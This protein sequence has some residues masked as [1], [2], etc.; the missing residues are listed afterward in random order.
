MKFFEKM[1]ERDLKKSF[2]SFGNTTDLWCT[3]YMILKKVF[4]SHPLLTS[5][6]LNEY[7]K[8]NFPN[9]IY[10]KMISQFGK[11]SILVQSYCDLMNEN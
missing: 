9:S 1:L 6:E 2:N 4:E 10:S 3:K 5:K 8:C 7:K 11:N